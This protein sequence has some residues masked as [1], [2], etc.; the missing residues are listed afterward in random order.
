MNSEKGFSL[1]EILVSLVLLGLVAA[2]VAPVFLSNLKFITDN[3]VRSGAIAAAQV[4]LDELR[5]ED[6]Y[7]MPTSGSD[8]AE[9]ITAGNKDYEVT[10]Y[11]CLDTS[12]CA[13][14]ST[15]H[16]TLDIDYNGTT[17]YSI[18]T[19]FTALQ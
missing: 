11:Y 2:G 8:P 16:L 4:K 9:V 19:V 10:T 18:E 3:E 6:P 1:I 14:T 17:V 15:R 12:L 5:F 13:T 7:G